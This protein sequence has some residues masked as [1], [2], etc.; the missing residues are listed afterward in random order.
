M[1]GIVD[2]AGGALLF[3][4]YRRKRQLPSLLSSAV[5]TYLRTMLEGIAG[6]GRLDFSEEGE[7]SS[8]IYS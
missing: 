7:N 5:C 1:G 8:G 2:E 3:G 6:E 4:M